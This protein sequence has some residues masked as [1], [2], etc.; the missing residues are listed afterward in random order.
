[1]TFGKAQL[2]AVSCGVLEE[3]LSNAHGWYPAC[4]EL[5]VVLLQTGLHFRAAG[6]SER[7]VIEGGSY[8]GKAHF[9]QP[10]LAQVENAFIAGIKPV[11]RSPEVGPLALLEAHNVTIEHFEVIH[12]LTRSA[13]IV[14][15]ETN[16]GHMD[17]P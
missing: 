7:R 8:V 15:V 12:E 6:A 14:M 3:Q 2:H 11:S 5:D 10:C 13:Q 17:S 16:R 4:R 9:V 1:M